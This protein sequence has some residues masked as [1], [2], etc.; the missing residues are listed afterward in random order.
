[1]SKLIR[2]LAKQKMLLITASCALLIWFI[3]YGLS[4]GFMSHQALLSEINEWF[5]RH[6]IVF[7]F[8]HILILIAIYFGWEFKI[9]RVEKQH[10]LSPKAIKKARDF[11]WVLISGV[12]VIDLMVIV[13]KV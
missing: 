2:L 8:W 7:V 9:K 4:I 6:Q 13:L 5:T 10:K 12:L 3:A 1:M 11:K